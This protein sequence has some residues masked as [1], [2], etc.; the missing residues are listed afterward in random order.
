MARLSLN[1][2]GRDGPVDQLTDALGR[3]PGIGPKTAERLAHHLMKC[4]EEEA[5]ALARAVQEVRAR[6]QEELVDLVS[7]RRSVWLG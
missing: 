7:H 2:G 6:I 3:L 1:P 5:L 4:P